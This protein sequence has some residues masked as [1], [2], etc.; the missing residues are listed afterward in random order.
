LLEPTHRLN[1]RDTALS[2]ACKAAL[3]A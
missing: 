2:L 1:R 3:P